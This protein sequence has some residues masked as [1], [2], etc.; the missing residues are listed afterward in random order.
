MRH[1]IIDHVT[2]GGNS[3]FFSTL[4]MIFRFFVTSAPWSLQIFPPN[5]LLCDSHKSPPK[6]RTHAF[7]SHFPHEEI[8]DKAK[9]KH[10][11]NLGQSEW[12]RVS[13]SWLN[14]FSPHCLPAFLTSEE[15][16]LI[17]YFGYSLCW[18]LSW[19]RIHK[20]RETH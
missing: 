5:I 2:R 4:L 18:F 19:K 1:A 3:L 14:A 17:Q 12:S 20:V 11:P 13:H 16:V 6:D 10:L 7:I 9:K 8:K 15:R